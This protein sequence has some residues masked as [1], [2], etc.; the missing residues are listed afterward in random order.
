MNSITP[1]PARPGAIPAP[2]DITKLSDHVC[3]WPVSSDASW[4]F[5]GQRRVHGAYCATHG[6]LAYRGF[7]SRRPNEQS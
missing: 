7:H 6:A 4:L 1:C 5:C 2:V 3:R